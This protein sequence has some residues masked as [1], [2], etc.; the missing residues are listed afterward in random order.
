MN[1]TMTTSKT[2]E[3]FQATRELVKLHAGRSAYCYLGT[4]DDARQDGDFSSAYHIENEAG[5]HTLIIENTE[6][7]GISLY[8]LERQL[9]EHCKAVGAIEEP[10]RLYCVRV[11][12]IE[13]SEITRDVFVRA[14]SQ[15]EAATKAILQDDIE[16]VGEDR[17]IAKAVAREL[18]AE[19]T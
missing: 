1:V 10:K 3:E 12:G 4:G 15:D 16:D 5:G 13:V 9:F 8:E 17:F 18:L 14:A 7:H 6:T 11:Y 2:F 19:Q